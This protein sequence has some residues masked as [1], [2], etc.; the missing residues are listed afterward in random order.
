MH[1]SKIL[2]KYAFIIRKKHLIFALFALLLEG[3][4]KEVKR[5]TPML[6]AFFVRRVF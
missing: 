5:Q 6:L 2:T 1:L 4:R 3:S